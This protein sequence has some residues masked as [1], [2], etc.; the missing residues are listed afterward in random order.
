MSRPLF[1]HACDVPAGSGASGG[2]H[3][4]GSGWSNQESEASTG[5]GS[6]AGGARVPCPS[7]SGAGEAT[8][9][10]RLTMLVSTADWQSPGIAE[11]L[12]RLLQPMG[13][14]CLAARSGEEAQNLIRSVRVHIAVIDLAIPLH[15]PRRT[16][17]SVDP[18]AQARLDA[19]RHAQAA[20][21]ARLLQ[22]LRRLDSPPPTIVIRP[23][24]PSLRD[25]ARGLSDALR[26]GAFAVLDRPLHL[27]AMLEALRRIVARHYAN[28]WGHARSGRPAQ[29]APRQY[30]V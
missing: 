11:Q 16:D 27:E 21:G 14:Q 10:N 26:E 22:L 18:A 12:P 9:T 17:G 3:G 2:T 20:A 24:Q 4:G 29:P 23:P 1:F 8:P 25:S 19:A 28:A 5:F 13:I 7:G 6:G 15:A 30:R